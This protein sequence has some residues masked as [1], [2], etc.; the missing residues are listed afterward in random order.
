MLPR[1]VVADPIQNIQSIQA[2]MSSRYAFQAAERERDEKKDV[3]VLERIGKTE[4]A[5]E[6]ERKRFREET[7]EKEEIEQKLAEEIE[8]KMP[9]DEVEI[10][11]SIDNIIEVFEGT[12]LLS[13]AER[14]QEDIAED[15]LDEAK[16]RIE[17]VKEDLKE[18]EEVLVSISD[19]LRDAE[20]DGIGAGNLADGIEEL[21]K[22][23]RSEL[24]KE[25]DELA[26]EIKGLT[27][28]EAIDR[29]KDFVNEHSRELS[30][31]K[32]I[33]RLLDN[34][35][36][37]SPKQIK[38]AL[39][40]LS[41]E[42]RKTS[43][44]LQKGAE[45]LRKLVPAPDEFIKKAKQLFAEDKETLDAIRRTWIGAVIDFAKERLIVSDEKK[46]E[47]GKE[48]WKD[49]LGKLGGIREKPLDEFNKRL[50]DIL[51][52]KPK[53]L[54]DAR[55]RGDQAAL[56]HIY[57]IVDTL[58]KGRYSERLAEIAGLDDKKG[59]RGPVERMA[60]ELRR[61]GRR[62]EAIM[63]QAKRGDLQGIMDEL[64]KPSGD[65]GTVGMIMLRSVDRNRSKAKKELIRNL[66][67]ELYAPAA[68]KSMAEGMKAAEDKGDYELVDEMAAKIVQNVGKLKGA[69]LE[70]SVLL[71]MRKSPQ[72]REMVARTLASAMAR[73][74]IKR[75]R[76]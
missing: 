18:K 44:T 76:L 45:E 3:S 25:L 20:K 26:K 11:Q 9:E 61:V 49:S 13:V 66:I 23:D 29:V 39:K 12:G 17:K 69:S 67:S 51:K 75:R 52:G 27:K 10:K 50:A 64:G 37:M 6:R 14:V 5:E 1:A 54:Q 35:D 71:R 30:A 62:A 24:Q 55:M 41:E 60:E 36:K 42:I 28:E 68:A 16:E 58:E 15:R 73:G 43:E 63:E 32:D 38:D 31:L 70:L 46:D 40:G 7:Q 2:M 59:M 19:K 56:N 72:R 8:K 57:G 53:E 48:F 34:W 22:K 4:E 33:D 65:F 74:A 47:K 21:S